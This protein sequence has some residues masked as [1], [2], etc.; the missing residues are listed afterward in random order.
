MYGLTCAAGARAGTAQAPSGFEGPAG[1][2]GP[3]SLRG[4]VMGIE[5]GHKRRPRCDRTLNRLWA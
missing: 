4:G 2:P 5:G 3:S 1:K